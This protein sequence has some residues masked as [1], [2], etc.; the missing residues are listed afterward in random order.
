MYCVVLYRTQDGE[1]EEEKESKQRTGATTP[2][3]FYVQY[4]VQEKIAWEEKFEQM[5]R[6]DCAVMADCLCTPLYFLTAPNKTCVASLN[7]TYSL[8]V[9]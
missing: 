1:T 3:C 5:E 9:A 4:Q 8:F 7:E 6:V 2:S